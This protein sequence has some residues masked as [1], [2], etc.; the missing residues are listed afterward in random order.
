MFQGNTHNSIGDGAISYLYAKLA[1]KCNTFA[2]NVR[3]KIRDFLIPYLSG[4]F[5]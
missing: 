5:S 1:D 2:K 3:E 4:V